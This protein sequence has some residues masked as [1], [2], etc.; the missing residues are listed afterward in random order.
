MDNI[1]ASGSTR[2]NSAKLRDYAANLIQNQCLLSR[3]HNDIVNRALQA[4]IYETIT[5]KRNLEVKLSETESE[6]HKA[7]QN[8]VRIDSALKDIIPPMQVNL[9][10][11]R[12][13][14]T[15]RP[16]VQENLNDPPEAQLLRERT[17]L[18][19]SQQ[20]MIARMEESQKI[21]KELQERKDWLHK[22]LRIKTTSLEIDQNEV[23]PR[24]AT[25]PSESTIMGY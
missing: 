17:A 21:L 23:L 1:S 19:T 10:R 4:R 9:T 20:T 12:H 15:E 13:R 7:E 3:K 11:R 6:F 18:N 2:Q 14:N 8:A 24:R 25:F 22:E 16:V 5:Q